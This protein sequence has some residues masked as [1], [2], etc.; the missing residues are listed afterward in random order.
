MMHYTN[1]HPHYIYEYTAE[2]TA[3]LLYLIHF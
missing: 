2:I 1:L 3:N